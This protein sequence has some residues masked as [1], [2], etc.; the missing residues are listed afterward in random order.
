MNNLKWP[1]TLYSVLNRYQGGNTPLYFVNKLGDVTYQSASTSSYTKK[2][3]EHRIEDIQKD[4]DHFVVLDD[5]VVYELQPTSK[6]IMEE[7]KENT[8]K[9]G[10]CDKKAT[11]VKHILFEGLTGVVEA[12]YL[13]SP[14]CSSNCKVY[15]VFKETP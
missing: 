1:E 8:L 10:I 12:S 3:I 4:I 11:I 7:I 9:C 14:F 13:A 6:Q 2:V 15:K 5:Y